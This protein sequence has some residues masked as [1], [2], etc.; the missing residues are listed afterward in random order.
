GVLF[1]VGLNLVSGL[2]DSNNR[3]PFVN[4]STTTEQV[5]LTSDLSSQLTP[6]F[7][8][9]NIEPTSTVSTIPLL[10]QASLGNMEGKLLFTYYSDHQELYLLNMSNSAMIR[11]AD[12][13]GYFGDSI[14]SPDGAKIIFVSDD[15]GNDE[16]YRID[17]DGS[18][19][20]NLTENSDRDGYP[21]WLPDSR[22]SFLSDRD[23]GSDL[24][25]FIM[26][27]DGSEQTK[28]N[29]DGFSFTWSPDGTKIAYRS[30]GSPGYLLNVMNAD[31]SGQMQL[32]VDD[33]YEGPEELLWSPDSTRLLFSSNRDGKDDLYIINADGSGEVRLTNNSS[34]E[35][36]FAWS[37]DATKILFTFT[38]ERN[39]DIYIINVDGT[40]LLKI[41]AD[42]GDDE[43][44]TWSPNGK[45]IAFVRR[46][47]SGANGL[48]VI[49]P[50]GTG[51][52]Q[53]AT[54]YWINSFF[55]SPDSKWIVF[56]SAEDDGEKVYITRA[57]G[58]GYAELMDGK[59]V[60]LL[61][62]YP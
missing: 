13:L 16:I 58:S 35:N 46:T 45:Q 56:R 23:T 43:D 38:S 50:D 29:V 8:S 49:N 11:L 42:E 7:I 60:S 62:W 40:G 41:T 3:F 47:S 19:Q 15:E 61:G 27:S 37:P 33:P 26:N 10:N 28:L 59:D 57:D 30:S 1:L 51:F 34:T 14:V 32:T 44:P 5:P 52:K 22:I 55:W 24:D 2:F 6:V 48:F 36:S 53:L 39:L 54:K 12:F 20:I 9:N 21:V 18:N 17:I 4:S 31:T 25:L